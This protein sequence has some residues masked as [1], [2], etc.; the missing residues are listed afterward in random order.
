MDYLYG[1][2][3]KQVEKVEYTG[4]ETDTTITTVDDINNTIEVDVKPI[5][6]KF[7]DATVPGS[8]HDYLVSVSRDDDSQ[9]YQFNYINKLPE[10]MAK[11]ILNSSTLQALLQAGDNI[12]ITQEK[13]QVKITS[14]AAPGIVYVS[15]ST[16]LSSNIPESTT[17]QK[18][19]IYGE[20]KNVRVGDIAVFPD[21]KN[22]VLYLGNI[23]EV[24]EDNI[25]VG[26]V[27]YVKNNVIIKGAWQKGQA[28]YPECYTHD[29]YNW[30]CQKNDIGEDPTEGENWL[31]LGP[32][33]SNT[34]Y[35]ALDTQKVDEGGIGKI[36]TFSS[37]NLYPKLPTPK[38]EDVVVFATEKANYVGQITLKDDALLSI[39]VKLAFVKVVGE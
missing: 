28:N 4:K 33:Q 24:T 34:T 12:S 27:K 26:N 25:T 30:L 6:P 2:L 1:E 18:N 8:E 32:V 17:L 29:G 37:D 38:V 9:T 36:Y 13:D 16:V 20:N 11:D 21:T 10:N 39:T 35:F 23:T 19:D 3:N 5:T 31:R 14:A 22:I 7:V 15:Q